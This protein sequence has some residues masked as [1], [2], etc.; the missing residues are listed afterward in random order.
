[1]ETKIE[2]LNFVIEPETNSPSKFNLYKKIKVTKKETEEKVDSETL[3][4]YGYTMEGCIKTIAHLKAG[5]PKR[6]IE[7]K[8]YLKEFKETIEEIKDYLM[9]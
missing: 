9:S 1:M 6:V 4:G 2:Y 3:I 7:L 8:Q 5:N